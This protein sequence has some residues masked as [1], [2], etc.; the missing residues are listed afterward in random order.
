[1]KAMSA[2]RVFRA[3]GTREGE[4]EMCLW[5][6]WGGDSHR[7]LSSCSSVYHQRCP[8]LSRCCETTAS[9]GFRTKTKHLTQCLSPN[10]AITPDLLWKRA[11]IEALAPPQCMMGFSF[12][13]FFSPHVFSSWLE[14]LKLEQQFTWRLMMQPVCTVSLSL[15]SPLPVIN[16]NLNRWCLLWIHELF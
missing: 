10:N 9:R 2:E 14:I 5:G 8:T 3:A 11:N 1:M 16:R 7:L 4:R 15:F 12:F 13:V 6:T